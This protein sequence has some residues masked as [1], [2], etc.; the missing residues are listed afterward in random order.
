ML[1]ITFAQVCFLHMYSTPDAKH[2]VLLFKFIFPL[3]RDRGNKKLRRMNERV[4]KYKGARG[5]SSEIPEDLVLTGLW[6]RSKFIC[7]NLQANDN[8]HYLKRRLHGISEQTET[9]Y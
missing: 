3:R 4:E 7:E 6:K 2:M 1:P 5:C 9:T 8:S